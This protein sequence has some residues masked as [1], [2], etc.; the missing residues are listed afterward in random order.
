MIQEMKVGIRRT[1]MKACKPER[2]VFGS[3]FLVD[4][5]FFLVTRLSG[6]P[7]IRRD[8]TDNRL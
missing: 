4:G 5:Q 6:G 1:N 3:L 2:D 8:L 7:Y